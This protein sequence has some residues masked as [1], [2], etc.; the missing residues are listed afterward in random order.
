ML[1]NIINSLL[2][3]LIKNHKL[4]NIFKKLKGILKNG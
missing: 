4:K 3:N 1:K 2:K